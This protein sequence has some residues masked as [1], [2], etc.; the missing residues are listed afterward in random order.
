MRTDFIWVLITFVQ[1][2]FVVCSA[3][4]YKGIE[5]YEAESSES[6]RS[7]NELAPHTLKPPRPT[8]CCVSTSGSYDWK[9]N[10]QAPGQLSVY[11]FEKSPMHPQ[12]WNIHLKLRIADRLNY[13]PDLYPLPS[14]EEVRRGG[15]YAPVS[16]CDVI[17]NKE[18]HTFCDENGPNPCN[19]S[20]NWLDALFYLKD[21]PALFTDRQRTRFTSPYMAI[22]YH[23]RENNG[24][25]YNTTLYSSTCFEDFTAPDD[26]HYGARS[27]GYCWSVDEYETLLKN[28][29]QSEVALQNQFKG[30]YRIVDAPTNIGSVTLWLIALFVTVVAAVLSPFFA[31]VEIVVASEKTIEPAPKRT[32]AGKH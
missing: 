12:A 13:Y 25:K 14:A 18:E 3:I 6:S 2:G 7:K 10:N 5:A 1:V 9:G 22:R 32:K 8:R 20:S 15:H 28:Q 31:V 23:W 24:R 21:V 11:K 19:A 27:P 17:I 30:Q 4:S 26:S 16:R 29:N